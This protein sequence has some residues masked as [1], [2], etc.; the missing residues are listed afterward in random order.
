MGESILSH[1]M[2]QFDKI[3][4][5]QSK[6]ET[7]RQRPDP[8]VSTHWMFNE[9]DEATQKLAKLSGDQKRSRLEKNH[10]ESLRLV[11]AMKQAHFQLGEMLRTAEKVFAEYIAQET[12][13]AG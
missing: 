4:G 8:H 13:R 5:E 6:R 7:G 10:A 9:I 12:G 11:Q 2:R 3:L 1:T